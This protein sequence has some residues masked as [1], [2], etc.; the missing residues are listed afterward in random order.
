MHSGFQHRNL[1]KTG[2]TLLCRNNP[3]GYNSVGVAPLNTLCRVYRRM[4][5]HRSNYACT[6]KLT[7]Q[8]V[9]T[10]AFLML[11]AS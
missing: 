1:Y 11:L 7:L 3:Q 9:F 5:L 6:H 8:H 10:A 2:S 4:Q